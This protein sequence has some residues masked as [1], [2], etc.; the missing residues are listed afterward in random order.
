MSA[1]TGFCPR[2]AAA[3]RPRRQ[4]PAV[5][6]LDGP[7]MTGPIISNTFMAISFQER[8]LLR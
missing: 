1:C 3:R 4:A 2:I 8:S 7:I 5:W 6:E